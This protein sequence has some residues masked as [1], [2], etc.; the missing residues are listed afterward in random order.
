[1]PVCTLLNVCRDKTSVEKVSLPQHTAPKHSRYAHC[2]AALRTLEADAS[3]VI[4]AVTSKKRTCTLRIL[5]H[6][7]LPKRFCKFGSRQRRLRKGSNTSLRRK[8]AG[9]KNTLY[10]TLLSSERYLSSPSGK[11]VT[12]FLPSLQGCCARR[13]HTARLAAEDMPQQ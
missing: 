3:A 11:T 12:T 7:L 9:L 6:G 5:P 1:M 10:L 13:R 2:P 8:E 4:G